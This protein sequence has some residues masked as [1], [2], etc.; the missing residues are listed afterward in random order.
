MVTV[1]V[2]RVLPH[3]VYAYEMVSIVD[4]DKSSLYDT[5][6]LSELMETTSSPSQPTQTLASF[7]QDGD[8]MNNDSL[9][10]NSSD[11]VAN[12]DFLQFLK[13]KSSEGE[14]EEEISSPNK[15]Q[16]LE[17][18]NL[19][20]TRRSNRL[21]TRTNEDEQQ[22][23]EEAAQPIVN[24]AEFQ[25][26]QLP[27]I[28]TS[29]P[30]ALAPFPITPFQSHIP[31]PLPVPAIPVQAPV[32]TPAPAPAR[33]PA[34]PR[35]KRRS[36]N[37]KHMRILTPEQRDTLKDISAQEIMKDMAFY[38]QHVLGNSREN[39]KNVMNKVMMLVNGYGVRHQSSMREGNVFRKGVMVSYI[40]LHL[41]I[42]LLTR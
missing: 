30:S 23:Q 5:T 15:K 22:P 24:T 14:T 27:V 9:L 7:N 36:V 26:Q 6:E 31:M 1:R 11:E 20:P 29:L 13:S 35:T 38:M 25:P 34:K 3:S 8:T 39:I 19:E 37:H 16:K 41:T 12:Y 4:E 10:G 2:K 28:N 40:S 32:P 33:A 21:T 42:P 17:S 18:A